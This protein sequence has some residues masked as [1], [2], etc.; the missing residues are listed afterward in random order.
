MSTLSM[1][2]RAVDIAN[3]FN[4]KAPQLSCSSLT[5]YGIELSTR[6][7][8]VGE[9]IEML[10]FVELAADAGAASFVKSLFYD[11]KAGVCSFELHGEI[12]NETEEQ[13]RWCA[14]QSISQ[15]MWI[16]GGISGKIFSEPS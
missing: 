9:M 12:D 7:S 8:K 5:A 6:Y 1:I 16:G 11:S 13:L 10:Q 15:Y 3:S 14:E 4:E 2:D